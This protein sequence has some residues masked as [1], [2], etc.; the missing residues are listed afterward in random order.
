[1]AGLGWDVGEKPTAAA[2]YLAGY[3]DE[4]RKSQEE[5]LATF[6]QLPAAKEEGIC[7]VTL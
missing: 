1:M 2:L 5:S 6:D 7:L 4:G 3:G